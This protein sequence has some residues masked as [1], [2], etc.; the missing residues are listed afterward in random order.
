M[1]SLSAAQLDQAK[2]DPASVFRAPEDVLS[3]NLPDDDKKTILLRWEADAEALMRATEEG[4]PP[5]DNRRGPGELLRAV[6]AA[7]GSLGA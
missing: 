5:D 4:M 6:Q 1:T 2:L 3:A 7:L